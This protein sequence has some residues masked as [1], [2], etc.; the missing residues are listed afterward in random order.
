MVGEMAGASIWLTRVARAAALGGS[1]LY[2][3]VHEL[4]AS[5]VPLKNNPQ[6][7]AA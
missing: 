5:T 6:E 7:V 1:L 3:G 2:R 4:T